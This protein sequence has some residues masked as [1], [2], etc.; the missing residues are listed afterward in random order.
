MDSVFNLLRSSKDLRNSFSRRIQILTLTILEVVCVTCVRGDSDPLI[1]QKSNNIQV[2]RFWGVPDTIATAGKLFNYSIPEDAF[3]GK[4]ES[5]EVLEAG[6]LTLP[7]WLHFDQTSHK[8]LGVPTSSDIDQYYISVKALG[9][10]SVD[11]KLSSGKDV[12]SIEVVP[13]LLPFPQDGPKSYFGIEFFKCSNG[14][15]VSVASVFVDC[16]FD[17]LSST[18][19]VSI[20]TKMASFAG[21]PTDLIKISPIKKEWKISDELATA[22]GPGTVKK[23]GKPG[24]IIQYQVSCSGHISISHSDK[25]SELECAVGNG[26]LGKSLGFGVI[27]WNVADQPLLGRRVKREFNTQGTPVLQESLPSRWPT[28]SEVE[29]P[30][31]PFD[32]SKIPESRVI[33][34]MAS[35]T[36]SLPSKHHRHHHGE[37]ISE[38][39]HEHHR[40]A[41]Q[42]TPSPTYNYHYLPTTSPHFAMMTPVIQPERPSIYIYPS[43]K[44]ELQSSRIIPDELTPVETLLSFQTSPFIT[45]SDTDVLP[46]SFMTALVKT[47]DVHPT[48]SYSVEKPTE[49][50]VIHKNF[51]PVVWN[52]I[53]KLQAYAGQV[54]HFEIP[55]DTFVDLEDGDTRN[56]KLIFMTERRTAISPSS[57]IQFDPEKQKLYALPMTENIGKYEFILEAMDSHGMSTFDQFEIQV[58]VEQSMFVLHHEFTVNL[59]YEKWKFPVDIDWQI[60]VVNR[61]EELYGDRDGAHIS[62]LSVT[63][64]PTSLT[65]TNI[66]LP[67]Y[68]CPWEAIAELMRK[69]VANDKGRPSKSLKQ[70]MKPDFNIQKI[71][72]NYHGICNQLPSSTPTFF[73]YSPMIKNPINRIKIQAGEILQFFIPEDTF[74]DN[75][76]G[77]TPNLKLIFLT[78]DQEELPTSSWIQF[79]SDSLK[80]FG[81][82]LKENIGIHEFQILAVDMEGKTVSDAFVVIVKSQPAIHTSVEFSMHIDTNFEQFNKNTEMKILVAQ[83]LAS[84]FGDPNT[85]YISVSSITNGSVIYTW[86][87]STLPS[88]PCPEDTISELFNFMFEDSE[89]ISEI[90]IKAMEP[91]FRI[92]Q[93]EVHPLG[94]CV[95]V[96]DTASAAVTPKTPVKEQV[97]ADVYITAVIPAVVIAIILIIA[98]MIACFLYRRRHRGKMK[99][100]DNSS[101][102]NKGIPI[103]F[104]DE[105]DEKPEST[106]SPSLTNEEKPPISSSENGISTEEAVQRTS[107]LS[108]GLDGSPD[109][110]SS[111]PYRPPPPF[112]TNRDSKNNRPKTTQTYRQ[113]P[114]PYVPP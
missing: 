35:P 38:G 37:D 4:V 39:K 61:L 58:W 40:D 48:K 36:F 103:I 9:P 94:A 29:G 5:Y 114:P 81:L 93:V 80:L 76:D 60:D 107:L 82:P 99:M 63:Q 113:P 109:A 101:Y 46:T 22:A 18:Q 73:N 30:E 16:S 27:G 59:K 97:G 96:V 71:L 77:I 67:H 110:S 85:K 106:T 65:W 44:E 23:R 41:V 6:E 52:H 24:V 31:E 1:L 15:S 91:E 79:D 25:I 45:Q 68:S 32:D 49:K 14:E 54:W 74:Y 90:F 21:V 64:D 12:F 86:T 2:K 47:S 83:K 88:F 43:V 50:P 19:R 26:S 3:T 33:P 17:E 111:P 69:L 28:F 51:K 42:V 13:E 104:A 100:Q 75:E 89:T 102:M 56:L 57:W 53:K 11:G 70:I 105:L 84:A 108:E 34:S 55:S 10:P 98:V 66:S 87:N 95:N 8:F 7:R 20:I 78:L 92:R 62:V 112:T 72:V